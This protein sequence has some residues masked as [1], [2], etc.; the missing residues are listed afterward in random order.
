MIARGADR[1][2]VS[3]PAARKTGRRPSRSVDHARAFARELRAEFLPASALAVFV[4]AALAF[5]DTGHWHGWLFL[6]SVLGVCALHAGANVLNDYC[7]HRSGNDAINK[8]FIRPFTGG[9]RLIQQGVLRPNEVLGLGA[10]LI[11]VG[12]GVGSYLAF[13][14]GPGVLVFLAL[15]VLAGVGYSIPRVGLAARGAG[16]ATVALAF[17]V[18]PVVGA[19]YVQTGT[20]TARAVVISLPVAVLIAAVLFINQFPDS[21]ADRAVGKRHWVVRLGPERA[22]RVYV[23]LMGLWVGL[24]LLGVGTGKIPPFLAWAALPG[25]L[26]IPASRR[27]LRHFDTPAAQAPAHALTILMHLLVT[28][29]LGTMLMLAR[30]L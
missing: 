10:A 8:D 26:A 1:A 2:G 4:G 22:A 21:R 16:E 3:A 29:A 7:D 25:L 17:G 18:L 28:A 14:V 6:V 30:M 5:Y 9:S 12:V 19:Y 23:A 20:V 11:G 27:V 24:L 13:R 15:G